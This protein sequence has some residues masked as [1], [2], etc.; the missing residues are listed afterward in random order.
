MA[1]VMAAMVLSSVL[2]HRPSPLAT[3][4]RHLQAL[5]RVR[6]GSSDDSVIEDLVTPLDLEV[7]LDDAGSALVLVDFHAEWCGPCKQIA[8]HLEAL[9][10]KHGGG[11]KV[12]FYKVDV[13]AAKEL[14]GQQGVRSMPTI[15]FFRNGEKVH[16]IVGGD[17]R[18]IQ[19]EVAKATMNPIMRAI[20]SEKVIVLVG[21]LYLAAITVPGPWQR[22]QYA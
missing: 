8:P 21:A 18:A 4:A 14:A 5:D 2:T 7:A 15:Q 19:E 22:L 12:M 11:G 6:G 9:A 1:I 16:E 20:R 13:D 3:S 17:V 10:R